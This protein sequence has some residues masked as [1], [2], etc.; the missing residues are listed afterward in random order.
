MKHYILANQ[1]MTSL[2]SRK[3]FCIILIEKTS[4]AVYDWSEIFEKSSQSENSEA[5]GL[6]VEKVISAHAP[7]CTKTINQKLITKI[8][9]TWFN[10]PLM[11]LLNTKQSYLNIWKNTGC[12][13]AHREY[14]KVRNLFN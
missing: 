3:E 10:K 11:T 12:E 14:K 13:V 4:I 1:K 2:K 7:Y 5:F 8:K 9:K 6:I